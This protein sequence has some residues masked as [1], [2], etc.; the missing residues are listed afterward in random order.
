MFIRLVIIQRVSTFCQ[1][2]GVLFPIFESSPQVGFSNGIDLY[3]SPDHG[4]LGIHDNLNK[5]HDANMVLV[6][7]KPQDKRCIGIR[8]VV[9]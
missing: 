7:T 1:S 4:P 2:T 5:Q 3:T 8:R 9:R 6:L